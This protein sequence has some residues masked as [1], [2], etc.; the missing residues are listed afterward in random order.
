MPTVRVLQK[1]LPERPGLVSVLGYT[2][3][4]LLCGYWHGAF[5]GAYL[6]H[7]RNAV[8]QHLIA[9]DNLL[10]AAARRGLAITLNRRAA[11]RAKSAQTPRG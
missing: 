3:T 1:R 11:K 5:G 7:L 2:G 4:F 8:F 10:D 6:P 9:A